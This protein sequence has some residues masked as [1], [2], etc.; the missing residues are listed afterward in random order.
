[1]LDKD[2]ET[3]TFDIFVFK[4]IVKENELVYMACY[5]FQK[6]DLFQYLNISQFTFTKFIKRIQS[7]YLPNLYHNSTHAA[8]VLQVKLSVLVL[9]LTRY[10]DY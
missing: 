8:D 2:A 3:V 9:L 6:R 1:M 7:G 4:N 10:L 5:L